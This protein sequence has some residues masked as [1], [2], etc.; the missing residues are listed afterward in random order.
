MS[1]QGIRK[2]KVCW[3][4]ILRNAEMILRKMSLYVLTWMS[5]TYLEFTAPGDKISLGA[6]PSPSVAA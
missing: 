2:L 6:P 4:S 5:V 3:T 1:Q